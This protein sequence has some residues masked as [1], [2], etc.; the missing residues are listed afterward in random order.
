MACK[1]VTIRL[2]E[3]PLILELWSRILITV[4]L[5]YNDSRFRRFLDHNG[6]LVWTSIQL[7]ASKNLHFN[8]VLK[9]KISILD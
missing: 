4:I 3:F 8:K 7:G 6:H 2:A 5:D 9:F 1:T